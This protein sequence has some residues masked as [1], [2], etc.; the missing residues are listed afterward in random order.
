MRFFI[1]QGIGFIGL[2]LVFI[3]FQHNDRRKIL[4]IQA[5]GSAVFGLHFFLLGAF[6]GMGMNLMEIPRNLTFARE[7]KRKWL[8]TSIFI[9]L[10]VVLGVF[11]WESPR[12]LF[13]MIAMCLSTV[14]FSLQKPRS[15]RFFTVPVSV[16][17][18]A[19]NV[20]SFSI[21]G[22]LTEAFCLLSIVIAIFRYDI[23]RKNKIKKEN[24]H[25]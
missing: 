14:V 3:A 21:A 20:F 4:W 17:W 9:A 5:A 16:L 25:E 8:F 10:F 12:S 13:P 19:Y 22:V 11:T 6:T 18:M 2:A 24:D 1:A 15:I 7:P 23:L